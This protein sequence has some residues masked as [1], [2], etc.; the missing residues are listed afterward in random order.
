MHHLSLKGIGSILLLQ[1]LAAA[2]NSRLNSF[3]DLA[4][5]MATQIYQIFS[6]VVFLTEIKGESKDGNSID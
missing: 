1:A 2:T 6:V 5:H 3:G 4:H